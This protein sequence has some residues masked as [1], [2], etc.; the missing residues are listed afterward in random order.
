MVSRSAVSSHQGV[1]PNHE[2]LP[3]SGSGATS[4]NGVY[5]TAVGYGTRWYGC[6]HVHVLNVRGR[7]YRSTAAAAAEL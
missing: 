7:V 1:S 4:S 2:L 5:I 6:I 3:V